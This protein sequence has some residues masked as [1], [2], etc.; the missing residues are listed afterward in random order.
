MVSMR[1][2]VFCCSTDSHCP[3]CGTTSVQSGHQDAANKSP[4]N[5]QEV[6]GARLVWLLLLLLP[7]LLYVFLSTEDKIGNF[8]RGMDVFLMFMM[9]MIGLLLLF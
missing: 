9:M 8:D 6:V 5:K 1:A 3:I 7:T 2:A 4:V